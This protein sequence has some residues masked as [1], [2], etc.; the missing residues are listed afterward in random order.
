VRASQSPLPIG[1]SDWPRVSTFKFRTKHAPAENSLGDMGRA[2]VR[3]MSER[4]RWGSGGMDHR[5]KTKN[6]TRGV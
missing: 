3:Q 6:N 5:Q 1:W 2:A 4:Q